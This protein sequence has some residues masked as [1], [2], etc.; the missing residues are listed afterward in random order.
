MKEKTTAI[1]LGNEYNESVAFAEYLELMKAQGK[2]RGQLVKPIAGYEGFYVITE[3]GEV[4]SLARKWKRS[5]R[6]LKHSHDEDG[7]PQISLSKENRRITKKIHRLVALHF[8]ENPNGYAM[9]NHLD[10]VKT[11]N[12]FQNL[13]WCTS[14]MNTRHAYKIGLL[15]AYGEYNGQSKLTEAQVLEIL[16]SKL[17]VTDLAR[18]YRVSLS[19]ISGIRKRREWKHLLV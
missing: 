8:I 13:E 18:Q 16:N 9:I 14:S 15:K 1:D 3:C 17:R 2:V 10:G 19:A 6:L 11:N 4:I 12:H 5:F 7:Y